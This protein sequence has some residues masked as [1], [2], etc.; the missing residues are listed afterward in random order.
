MRAMTVIINRSMN[1]LRLLGSCA[2]QGGNFLLS[3]AP[4]AD[5]RIDIESVERLRSIGRWMKTNGK[6]IYGAGPS[7][8][9]S[10]QSRDGDP[11]W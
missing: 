2:S 5:G 6:A 11:R 3:V 10:A 7:P 9:G 4:D 8:I 1:L